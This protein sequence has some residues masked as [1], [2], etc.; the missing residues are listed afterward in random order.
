MNG[1]EHQQDRRSETRQSTPTERL[2]WAR[3]NDKQTST[4]WVSNIATRSVAFVT[5]TRS[6]PSPGE[7]IELTFG[8]SGPSP[9][10]REFRVVRAA[11]YDE[12]FSVVG[13]ESAESQ[14]QLQ[15]D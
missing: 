9:Q 4:G 3:E 6:L 2:A 13:C 12:F 7:A 11:P 1:P 14:E 5:P 8:S 15:L 10:H